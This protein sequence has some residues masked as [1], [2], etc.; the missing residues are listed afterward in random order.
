MNYG[1]VW[2]QIAFLWPLKC[3]DL[4]LQPTVTNHWDCITFSFSNVWQSCWYSRSILWCLNVIGI[5]S[6]SIH[7]VAL[8]QTT[9]VIDLSS[10]YLIFFV[11]KSVVY[12][13]YCKLTKLTCFYMTSD[14]LW[15][16]KLYSLYM[17]RVFSGQST[18]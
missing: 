16:I 2:P 12:L 17:F 7:S 14:I 3:C 15:A 8:L 6:F 4:W 1:S 9:S 11:Y 13:A 5:M 10:K 18:L